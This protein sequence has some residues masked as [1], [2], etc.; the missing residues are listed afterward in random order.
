MGIQSGFGLYTPKGGR[1]QTVLSG[2]VDGNGRPNALS[3]VGSNIIRLSGSV[4]PLRLSLSAG[5]DAAGAVEYYATFGSESDQTMV[6]SGSYTN[7]FY[8]DRAPSTGVLTFGKTGIR[9]AYQHTAPAA[10]SQPWFD[11]NTYQM[12]VWSG[13]AWDPIQRVYVGEAEVVSGVLQ[14]PITYAYN[15]HYYSN[16]FFVLPNG[17]YPIAHNLGYTGNLYQIAVYTSTTNS[18]DLLR[19][20][21]TTISTWNGSTNTFYGWYGWPLT[22]NSYNIRTNDQPVLIDNTGWSGTG[23]LT[24]AFTRNF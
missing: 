21:P 23:Y 12:R 20:T 13:T 5:F 18:M 15:G 2:P 6:L 10:T 3:K 24:A 17:S 7:W 9:P 8:V 14:N 22:P 19:I 11:L 4:T 1:R 16:L